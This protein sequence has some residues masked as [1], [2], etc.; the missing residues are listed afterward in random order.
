MRGGKREAR[1]RKLRK[2]HGHE[3]KEKRDAKRI[4]RETKRERERDRDR[5]RERKIGERRDTI[6]ECDRARREIK[7]T[8]PVRSAFSPGGNGSQIKIFKGKKG[9]QRGERQRI[10]ERKKERERERGR[11]REGEREGWRGCASINKNRYINLCP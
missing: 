8:Q 2:E 7:K 5:E 10:K 1:E 3:K 11:E 4:K 6:K 9:R